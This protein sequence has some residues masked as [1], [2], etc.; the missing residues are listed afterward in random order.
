MDAAT[1]R[2]KMEHGLSRAVTNFICNRVDFEV[3][4]EFSR[5]PKKTTMNKSN[6]TMVQLANN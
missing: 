1:L 5:K 6:L 2:W 3:Q 4:I